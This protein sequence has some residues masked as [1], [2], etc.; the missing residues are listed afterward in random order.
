[1]Q[2][3]K[4]SLTFLPHI[5]P[6]LGLMLTLSIPPIYAAIEGYI[7]FKEYHKIFMDSEKMGLFFTNVKL[8]IESI[9]KT[10]IKKFENLNHYAYEVMK[11]MDAETNDW[12][13]IVGKPITPGIG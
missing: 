1:M 3:N 9:D 2:E 13:I 12:S 6:W 5:P 4:N 8:N 10:L 7:Y 11:N